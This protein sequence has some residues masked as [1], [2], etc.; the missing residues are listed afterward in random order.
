[1][2][3]GSWFLLATLGGGCEQSDSRSSTRKGGGRELFDKCGSVFN[4]SENSKKKEG[5]KQKKNK[6]EKE[7]WGQFLGQL[8]HRPRAS[9]GSSGRFYSIFSIFPGVHKGFISGQQKGMD[10]RF[11]SWGGGRE[12]SHQ[13]SARI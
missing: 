2:R 7:I 5:E 6:K 9:L 13:T 12:G 1:M 3:F 10:S 4:G 8:F 11:Q